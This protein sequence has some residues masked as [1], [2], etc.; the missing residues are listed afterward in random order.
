VGSGDP[1][2]NDAYVSSNQLK[3]VDET[4]AGN[5][6][7]VTPSL[8][9]TFTVNRIKFSLNVQDITV[10]GLSGSSSEW[11]IYLVNDLDTTLFTLYIHMTDEEKWGFRWSAG[12]DGYLTTENQEVDVKIEFT[13]SVISLWVDDESIFSEIDL[14]TAGTVTKMKIES[15]TL[16]GGPPR[17][18]DATVIVDDYMAIRVPTELLTAS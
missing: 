11:T 17:Q 10:T 18:L 1:G 8:T 7:L 15:C 14:D 9:G 12:N 3:I 16:Y 13:T 4:G 6:L 2:E 5:V